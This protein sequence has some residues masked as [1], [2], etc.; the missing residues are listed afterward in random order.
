MINI[1]IVGAEHSHTVAIAKTIN[2]E[3]RIPGVRV[4]S[5]WGE[6][7]KVARDASDRG[8]I[9]TIVASP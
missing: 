2:I 5:V 9:P 7:R 1:G 3:K 4:V 8:K 6:S